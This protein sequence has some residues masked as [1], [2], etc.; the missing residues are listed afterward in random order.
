[1]TE[2]EEG[3]LSE[4]NA[5]TADIIHNIKHDLLNMGMEVPEPFKPQIMEI[6][7]RNILTNIIG[8]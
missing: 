3:K 5:R 8:P 4:I 2:A 6:L 1:M 7:I